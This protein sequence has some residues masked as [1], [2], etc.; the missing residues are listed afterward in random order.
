MATHY[1][2]CSS[3]GPGPS[4][5]ECCCGLFECVCIPEELRQRRPPVCC[6]VVQRWSRMK[7]TP[8]RLAGGQDAFDRQTPALTDEIEA[9][10]GATRIR[11]VRDRCSIKSPPP[12][13]SF[14]PRFP[15]ARILW[16]SPTTY[17][18]F[19]NHHHHCPDQTFQSYTPTIRT[20]TEKGFHHFHQ[21]T[22]HIFVPLPSFS[23]LHI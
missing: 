2:F 14:P 3:L 10:G 12:S 6:L 4:P 23:Y 20:P 18:H 7:S 22:H 11:A 19:L 21:P 9:R 16:P 5:G 8:S 13:H 1:C 15:S 17:H